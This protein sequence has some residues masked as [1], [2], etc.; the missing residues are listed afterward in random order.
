MRPVTLT[1]SAFGPYAGKTVLEMDR[2]G[3]SGLYL[4]TGDTGAGKTTLFDAIT[5]ALYGEA[6]GKDREPVM[7][8][9]KY[10]LPDTPTEVELTFAYGEKRY[11]VKRNPEFERPARRGG[12]MTLQRAEAELQFPDGRRVTKVR[13]VNAAIKEILGI[14]REQFAQIAMIAQGDFLRLLFASTEE[15]INI[16]RKIFKTGPFRELQDC[17]RQE[18][19][20][21]AKEW[22]RLGQSVRQYI[23]GV[24]CEEESPFYKAFSRAWKGELLTGDVMAL[25]EKTG[26]QDKE[27]AEK[28]F[29]KIKNLEEEAER[30]NELLGKAAG[31]EKA[32]ASLLEAREAR[33][34]REAVLLKQKEAYEAE[35]ERRPELEGLKARAALLNRQLSRYGELET[36]KKR[37]LGEEKELENLRS[38][39]KTQREA[40]ETAKEELDALEKES[41]QL[42]SVEICLE[43]LAGEKKAWEGE[44]DRFHKIWEDLGVYGNLLEEYRREQ[45]EYCQLFARAEKLT[46]QYTAKNRIFLDGQAGVL[47]KELLENEPCPV[48]GSREHPSPAGESTGLPTG[49]ELE[50]ARKASEK[51]QKEASEKSASAGRAGGQAEAKGREI[52]QSLGEPVSGISLENARERVKQKLGEISARLTELE[53]QI[54]AEKQ[55]L[56]RKREIDRELPQKEKKIDKMQQNIADK[57]KELILKEREREYLRA[58]IEKQEKELDLENREQAEEALI[59]LTARTE[60]LQKAYEEAKKAYLAGN[61]EMNGLK[62]RIAS[63]EEQIKDAPSLDMEEKTRERDALRGQC[64]LLREE[65]NKVRSRMEINSMALSKIREQAD[66]LV[67]T[68]KQWSRVNALYNTASGNITGKER[69]KLETYIQ[70]KYFERIIDRANLRFMVMSGGQYE[71]RRRREADDNRH[72]SGLELDVIDHYNGTWRSV[73]TLSGGE[74]FKASLSLALG[75]SDEIQSMAGGIRLDTM[76]V[77]EGFGSL[78]EESLQ[79][80]VKALAGLTE[81]HRLV[82]IISHVGELKE[83]IDRQIVVRKDRTGGSRVEIRGER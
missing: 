60:A 81:G 7:L 26:R 61:D 16:F 32:R 24:R 47:A 20:A 51:A 77:D 21:L 53:G 41:R 76:F 6:S 75:L 38:E 28:L 10:A 58:D 79:Q 14:D 69:I 8:R 37:L 59:A 55:R 78:D 72:Q 12:G 23:A 4:I 18:A 29:Q 19:A 34:E 11:T 36:L 45:E 48:C 27:E 80:A 43:R 56:E 22:D 30:L 17:L 46:A 71:L 73:K 63:L 83:K 65:L 57:E 82:G 50:K 35:K 54:Q 52:E 15:K 67:D 66:L 70:M 62:G 64:G 25:L 40:L 33:R 39:G 3:E 2:L 9:S 13:E 31:I 68:E 1:M 49:G 44:A 5:F 42:E 74:S